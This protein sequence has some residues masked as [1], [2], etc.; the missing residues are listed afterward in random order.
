MIRSSINGAATGSLSLPCDDN[1]NNNKTKE[2]KSKNGF[3]LT[4]HNTTKPGYF[5]F[6]P[7]TVDDQNEVG[8]FDTS[9]IKKGK[10]RK[11]KYYIESSGSD[12]ESSTSEDEP[13]K[14]KKKKRNKLRDKE[15]FLIESD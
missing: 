12:T 6:W 7:P 9:A 13:P 15:M 3:H 2:E 11:I 5:W 10:K 8:L 4:G 14:P 1:N